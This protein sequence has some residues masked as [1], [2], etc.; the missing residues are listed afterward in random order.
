MSS[1][2]YKEKYSKYKEKYLELKKN[3]SGGR[4]D[5]YTVGI[6]YL[7]HNQYERMKSNNP[8][9]THPELNVGALKGYGLILK[10]LKLVDDELYKRIFRSNE[11]TVDNA[12]HLKELISQKYLIDSVITNDKIEDYNFPKKNPD[13][14]TF[15][16]DSEGWGKSL[17]T[18]ARKKLKKNDGSVCVLCLVLLLPLSPVLTSVSTTN[19]DD[20]QK[21]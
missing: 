21:I 19:V 11:G 18:L 6:G 10:N 20:K 3:Q 12:Q 5:Q 4:I 14:A 8:L 7:S 1:E 17:N 13:L 15:F 2:F 9:E 16:S